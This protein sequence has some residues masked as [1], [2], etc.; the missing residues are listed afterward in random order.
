V[1]KLKAGDIVEVIVPDDHR[2]ARWSGLSFRVTEIKTS[3]NRPPYAIGIVLKTPPGEQYYL[4]GDDITWNYLENLSL[5][6]DD[7]TIEQPETEK[8]FSP[9][10]GE[11]T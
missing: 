2:S 10:S 3:P 1:T 8:Y 9:F 4:I 5:V 6:S 11:W 7:T